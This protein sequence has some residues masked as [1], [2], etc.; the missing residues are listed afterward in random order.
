M[1]Y[2][3]YNFKNEHKY[4]Q[5]LFN[6]IMD[7][8]KIYHNSKLYNKLLNNVDFKNNFITNICKWKCNWFNNKELEIS[9]HIPFYNVNYEKINSE[10]FNDIIHYKSNYDNFNKFKMIHKPNDIIK[11]KKI[12]IDNLN[13]NV[14]KLGE[15]GNNAIKTSI[16]KITN[17]INNLGKVIKSF[18]YEIYPNNQQ[19]NIL[20][21]WFNEC[22]IVYNECIKLN[23]I[24]RSTNEYIN[25]DYKKTKLDIFQKLYN[26]TSKPAPYDILTD[27]VRT[28]CSNL[29]S[30]ITNNKNGHIKHFN[31]TP[32]NRYYGRS[33]LIPKSAI[34]K[35]GFYSLLLYGPIKGFENININLINCDSRLVF[36]KYLNKYY[37]KCPIYIAVKDIENR[38]ETVA[39]DPGERIFMTYYSFNDCGMIGYDIRNKILNYHIK[40]KK[41]QRIISKKK[42]N[43]KSRLVRRFK[44]YY[45]KIKFLVKELHNKTALYL[46]RNYKQILI[47]K[48]ETSKMIGKTFIKNELSRI[49]LESQEKQQTEKRKLTKKVRLS[50]SVK[51]VLSSLSH[52]SFQQHLLHK[53]KEYGCDV[54]IVSEEY[55][56][57][58]CTKCGYLSDKYL[59]R[60]KRCPYC[61]LEI[62]RDINGSRNIL[63]K[64]HQGCYK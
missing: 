40:I 33:I 20:H 36:N 22:D 62:N 3:I 6:D 55:T 49:N 23:N 1:N 60:M 56:S 46:V 26:N 31:L 32:K 43:N 51:F 2:D 8:D 9:K 59:N 48:F 4:S 44:K 18:T 53:G 47:P 11:E 63:I 10:F 13:E 21:N 58:C 5:M 14:K 54:K 34:N 45:L 12:L 27:E 25:L 41:L 42:I 57:K 35:N 37:L 61:N 38:K 19:V 16:T 64:N 52:Y 15:T 7:Y 30:C 50:K 29:K 24:K 17:K 39:L 28:F